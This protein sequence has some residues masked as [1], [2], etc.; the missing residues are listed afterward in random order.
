MRCS[1]TTLAC[2]RRACLFPAGPPATMTLLPSMRACC[3]LRHRSHLLAQVF[4]LTL[5]RLALRRTSRMSG[6][7]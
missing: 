7:L 4:S 1:I 6:H 3:H 2:G 5:A